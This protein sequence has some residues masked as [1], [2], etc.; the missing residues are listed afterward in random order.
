MKRSINVL[1]LA[2][3]LLTV[4]YSQSI[5]QTI[6]GRVVDNLTETPLAYANVMVLNTV[7]LIGTISDE[8]G[9]FVIENVTVG[10]HNI[11]VTMMGYESYVLNELLISSGKQ[12]LLNVAM[13]QT[14]LQ[15]KGVAV[16]LKKD[17]PIN[18]MTTVSS[19]QFTVEETQ[20]YA[21]GM[22]DPAR[23]ASSFAGVA[24]PAVSSNGISVR[25]NNPEGLLWR[26]E[27]VETPNPNHFADLTVVGGGLIT[28]LS[29]QMLGNSDFYTGAFPAEY[30]NATS[31][32][33]DINLR[34]GNSNK[35]E[36]T[37]KAG[38]IGIDFAAQGPF[39]IDNDASYTMNYRYSTMALIAPIL[40]EDT[41]ILE[42]Q[43]LSFKTNFPTK[44]VGTFSIWGVGALDGQE[45]VAADSS[46]WKTNFD[47]D[48]S[49]TS[50]YMYA[51][52]LSHKI[53]LN[54]STFVKTTVSAT[55]N[56]L[57]HKEQRL[58]NT[59]NSNPQSRAEN[60]SWRYTIQSSIGKRFNKYHKNQIGFYYSQLG[61]NIDIEQVIVEGEA[62]VTMAKQSGQSGLLQFYTQSKLLLSQKLLL[63]AGL[64]YQHFL[65]NN[66]YSVEPRLGIKYNINEA[67]N[68]ALA[69]GLHSR[70]ER[71]PIYFV[72]NNGNNPNKNLDLMNSSHVVLAYNA[73]LN[74]N[75]RFC[76]EPYYQHLTNVP[77]APN[78]Y[79]S[80]INM[81]N[82]I[83][84]NETLVSKGTARN[85]GVDIT[86][87]RFLSNG[88]YYLATASLFDSKYTSTDN[89][90]RNT[91]FNKNYVLNLLVGQEWIVGK[92]KNNI[93]STNLRL[94]YLGGNRQEAIN[95]QA[96][97]I[98]NDI[99]YGETDGA[100]SFSKKYKDVPVLSLTISYRKNKPNYSSVLSLQ[101]LNATT[102]K[103]FSND[104]YNLNTGTISK[105]YDGIM[106]PNLSFSIEF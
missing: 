30:G 65:L 50:L 101:I 42:Y 45:M 86:L 105:K 28:A 33:F 93:F 95:K 69:Y 102:T 17:I 84:F 62:P 40:P 31:G 100:L 60:D 6:R 73:K 79:K 55:G 22:D 83:F 96:S 4:S 41:G 75:L 59:L 67:H 76:I 32:V 44:K 11:M 89:N 14:T 72:D 18:T 64:H 47:R 61:Y 85:I 1:L 15:M 20:R 12:P 34:T 53:A 21:G 74:D 88:F 90:E 9:Y 52:G 8:D 10:R 87:E 68:L 25:G 51:T 35:R 71:L 23:L 38:L 39:S 37:F 94:N 46:E 103:E 54:S 16:K 81:Q 98:E 13:Q 70:I 82:D 99:V 106:V 92:G 77:V 27:G 43:D 26:I 80:T 49:Q 97:I 7:P 2:I 58:D 57:L 56:G 104:Y 48:D 36:Y 29:N 3:A 63:N 66:K 24:T 91:R 78:S 5:T 19:R